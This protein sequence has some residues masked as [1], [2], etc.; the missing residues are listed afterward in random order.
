M[1][2]GN[3]D[4]V[5]RVSIYFEAEGANDVAKAGKDIEGG[6]KNVGKA[7]EDALGGGKGGKGGLRGLLDSAKTSMG[8]LRSEMAGSLSSLKGLGSGIAAVGGLFGQFGLAVAGVRAAIEFARDAQMRYN[9]TI[10]LVPD[11]LYRMRQGLGQTSNEFGRF[12]AGVEDAMARAARVAA[13]LFAVG[14]ASQDQQQRALLGGMM[15]SFGPAGQFT[16]A[17]AG[18]INFSGKSAV[19]APR[20]GGGGGG[21][22]GGARPQLGP[23][24]YGGMLPIAQSIIGGLPEGIGNAEAGSRLGDTKGLMSRWAS[25]FDGVGDKVS[26]ATEGLAAFRAQQQSLRD[27]GAAAVDSVSAS[28][29]ALG[30]SIG[31]A[32]L[33]NA[34]YGGSLKQVLATLGQTLSIEMGWLAL[35]Y[36]IR[37]YGAQASTFGVPNPASIGY[38]AAAGMAAA[39]AAGGF[40]AAKAF[41][42]GGGGGGGGGRLMGPASSGVGDTARSSAGNEP[43][44]VT[45]YVGISRGQVHDAVVEETTARGTRRGVPRL[46]MAT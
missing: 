13:P 32:A 8:A 42:G 4:V 10:N 46:A 24:S 1:A 26:A 5:K 18:L 34:L 12:A 19:A 43:T 14:A 15:G 38:F 31:K 21:G 11:L 9:D 27:E 28:F 45:V 40:V 3:A 39:A 33:A 44:N 25:D 20:G 36:T 6:L 35:E 23:T 30:E 29:G 41:G 22:G 16:A 2:S 17:G 7:G 37:G